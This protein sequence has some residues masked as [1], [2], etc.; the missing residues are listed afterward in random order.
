MDMPVWVAGPS[1]EEYHAVHYFGS[2][3]EGEE[4]VKLLGRVHQIPRACWEIKKSARVMGLRAIWMIVFLPEKYRAHGCAMAKKEGRILT[5]AWQV[6]MPNLDIVRG[7][8][9]GYQYSRHKGI[10][11]ERIVESIARGSLRS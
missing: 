8:I 1:N 7:W 2:K 3:K 6:V 5:D 9:R 4:I 10:A 11:A